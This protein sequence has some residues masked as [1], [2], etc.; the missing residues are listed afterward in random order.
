[1]KAMGYT[2]KAEFFLDK[3]YQECINQYTIVLK[4]GVSIIHTNLMGR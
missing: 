4:T 2:K 3:R 1:M